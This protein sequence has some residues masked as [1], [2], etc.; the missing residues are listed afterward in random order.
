LFNQ[1]FA[2]EES[3]TGWWVMPHH[4]GID[5]GRVVLRI[6]NYRSGLIWDLMRRRPAVIAGLPQAGFTGGVALTP[7]LWAPMARLYWK[8]RE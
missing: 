8:A 6:E 4:L 5:Q 1:T 2:V 3:P 7:G